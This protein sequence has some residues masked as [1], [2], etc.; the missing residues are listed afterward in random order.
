MTHAVT[1]RL[2]HDYPKKKA[3]GVNQALASTAIAVA[4]LKIRVNRRGEELFSL[5]LKRMFDRHSE[6]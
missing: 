4:R 5:P 6:R 1:H 3:P 2:P